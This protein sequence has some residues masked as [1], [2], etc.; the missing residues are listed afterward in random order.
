MESF[1]RC[2]TMV[3]LGGLPTLS[4]IY[5]KVKCLKMMK[6]RKLRE[7]A[8]TPFGVNRFFSYI[9]NPDKFLNC[10]LINFLY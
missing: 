3:F 5:E 9:A 7:I 4:N 10:T 1:L 2:E 6:Q 8:G